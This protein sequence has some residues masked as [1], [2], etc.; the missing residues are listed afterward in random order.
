MITTEKVCLPCRLMRGID[1]AVFRVLDGTRLCGGCVA[2]MP[3]WCDMCL[4]S[5]PRRWERSVAFRDGMKLCQKHLN[6]VVPTPKQT[7]PINFPP[8][9]LEA[10]EPASAKPLTS[11]VIKERLKNKVEENPVSKLCKC[12]CGKEASE[13]RDYAWGHKPKK[14]SAARAVSDNGASSGRFS[15]AVAQLRAERDKLDEAIRV[16]ESL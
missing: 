16:L 6:E 4:S 5:E 15:A 10:A 1:R 13:G 2:D 8:I 7:P 11:A 9:T 3:S 12:G 14:I